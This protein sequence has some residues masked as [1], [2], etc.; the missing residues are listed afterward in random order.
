MNFG[1]LPTGPLRSIVRKEQKTF[2]V[3]R[4][5][6]SGAYESDMTQVDEVDVHLYSPASSHSVALEGTGEETGLTGLVI[7]DR[8][9]NGDITEHVYGND[10]LRFKSDESVRYDVLTKDGVPSDLDPTLWR[11]GLEKSN[12]SD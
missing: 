7:P 3:Y 12:T 4:S 6:S 10:Q 9:T 8:D 1:K 2:V 5:D 11:L